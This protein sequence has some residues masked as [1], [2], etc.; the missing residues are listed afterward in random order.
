MIQNHILSGV[1]F[2][3]TPNISGRRIVP[4]YLVIHY[5]GSGTFEGA[6]RELTKKGS[7][8]SAHVVIGRAGEV[9]QI[10]SFDQRAWHCGA[11]AW[12]EFVDLNDRSIGIEL[13]NWGKLVRDKDG[14]RYFSWAGTEVPANQVAW[15]RHRITGEIHPWHTYTTAQI[16]KCKSIALEIVLE[17]D[18][19]EIIGHEDIATPKGRKL[20]PGPVFSLDEIRAVCFPPP[21]EKPVLVHESRYVHF[22]HIDEKVYVT[23]SDVA[24]EEVTEPMTMEEAYALRGWLNQ[25]L[26]PE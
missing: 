22:Q 17:Y 10:A 2:K 6:V 7:K 14:N 11:S 16:E 1:P 13:Q 26:L 15:A 21:I 24:G 5:T 12:K 4:Q 18:I 8:K 9:T 25:I 20:D 19:Q 23:I 3:Q